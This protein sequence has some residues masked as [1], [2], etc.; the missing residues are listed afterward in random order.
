MGAIEICLILLV[1]LT[2]S[3]AFIESVVTRE[4]K[5]ELLMLVTAEPDKTP[6]VT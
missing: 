5:G 4:L 6:C 3:V 2:A 1:I